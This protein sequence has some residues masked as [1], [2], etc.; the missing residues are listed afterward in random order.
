MNVYRKSLVVQLILFIVFFVIGANMIITFYLSDLIPWIG[1][2]LI[3]V[4]VGLGV[5]GFRI[6][7][8]PDTRISIVTQKEMKVVR[9]LLYGY[10][11]VYILQLILSSIYNDNMDL[12]QIINL[13]AGS[14]LMLIA[15]Y[16]AYMQYKIIRIK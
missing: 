7:R 10:F 4:L 14:I 12:L 2:V 3:A 9:Y 6:Y 5:V 16:G 13:A 11:I 1:Y 8:K 15:L